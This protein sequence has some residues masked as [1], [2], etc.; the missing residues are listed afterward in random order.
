MIAA[1]LSPVAP[2]APVDVVDETASKVAFLAA[3][4]GALAAPQS[5]GMLSEQALNGLFLVLCDLEQQLRS[6]RQEP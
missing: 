5:S 2:V 6:L 3:A 4:C 1:P